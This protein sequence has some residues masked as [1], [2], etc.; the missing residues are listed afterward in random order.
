MHRLPYT[1]TR[2]AP[3]MLACAL[4]VMLMACG[5]GGLA[6][7][8]V[9]RIA[10]RGPDGQAL[11]VGDTARVTATPLDMG[12][13][14]VTGRIVSFSSSAPAIADVDPATGLVTARM[15]GT[16]RITAT[17]DGQTAWMEIRVTLAPVASIVVTPETRDLHPQWTV[18]LTVA[19]ADAKGRPLT[20][21]QID[22]TTSNANVATADANGLVTAGGVGT[23]TITATS[24]GRSDV[25][26][27]TVTPAAVFAVAISPDERTM[28]DG[29]L[30]Q[31]HAFARD[32]RGITLPDRPITWE[33][34]DANVAVVSPTGMVTARVPGGV[35]ITARSGATS[36]SL[37]LTVRAHIET[38]AVTPA[39]D[40]LRSGEFGS[41][42]VFLAD[43]G[44]NRLV[45][46]DVTVTSSNPGIVAVLSDG[47]LRAM[48]VGTAVLTARSEGRSAT[49]TVIVIENVVF[50]R[51]IPTFVNLPKKSSF[52][53]TVE[54]LDPR[55]QPLTGRV[56]T[57]ESSNPNIATVDAAGVI[58]AVASGETMIMATC[59][60]KSGLAKVTVPQ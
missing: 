47:R 21:R 59:E 26:V 6:P 51:L 4:L 34:S 37:P 29:M 53:L 25:V 20:G 8:G 60:G 12:G 22:F 48:D 41:V 7:D 2:L 9:A 17:C 18:M 16:V 14:T 28:S 1:S 27:I 35:M 24:E 57:Y 56:V 31:Y 58:T 36:A 11:F 40:T 38:I 3:A 42:D 5:D 19:L 45:D 55:G 52:A 32:E 54:V 43:V 49:V 46:R 39:K 50:V 13:R 23:A 15:P 33:T 30:R 44:G 10:L